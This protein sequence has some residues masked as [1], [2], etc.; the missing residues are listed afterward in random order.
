VD[1]IIR[2]ARVLGISMPR[3][4][5]RTITYILAWTVFATA[6]LLPAGSIV[7]AG[8]LT[9]TKVALSDPRPSTASVNYTF[10]G[11]SVTTSTIKCIKLVF[12]TTAAGVTVPTGFNSSTS[13]ALN[14]GSTNY[15]PT[16][17][18]LVLDKTTNGTLLFTDATG[19]TP[20]SAST[21]TFSVNGLTN[22]STADT[23]YYLR[24][25]TYNNTDCATSPL[26]NAIVEFINTNSSILSLSV[27]PTLSFSIGAVSSA[28][29]CDG[30]TTTG[31]STAT[32]IPFGAVTA[33]ANGVV[34]QDLT[35]STNGTSGYSIF[36][37]YTGAP[38]SG[39]NFIAAHSGTNTAPTAFSAAGTE[40]YGYSTNDATL[41]T[42]TPNR[43][44]SP[45]P[46]W[47]AATTTNAEIGYESTPVTS[48][49]YRIGHQVGI[50]VTSPAGIYQTTIIYT[51]TPVY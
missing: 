15:V 51:C 43:F 32:T 14:T 39:S 19:Q 2:A 5:G 8:T 9:S 21:R 28:Q 18:S 27:D 25:N 46:A 30:T 33:G 49:S 11:S 24:I 1:R 36:I 40:A 48:T 4:A 37:R 45:S 29:S 42:G 50:S 22:S 31:T 35:A 38:Q 26:D 16:P 20:A 23:A 13:A 34:C 12:A 6:T 7:A 17:A 10:T 44:T 41:G 47:A 3:S